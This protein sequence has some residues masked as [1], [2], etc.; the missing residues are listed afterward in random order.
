MASLK[1]QDKDFMDI[2]LDD[3]LEDVQNLDKVVIPDPDRH[4]R[5]GAGVL[6]YDNVKYAVGLRWLVAEDDADIELAKSRAGALEADFYALR[7]NVARQQGFGYLAMGHRVGMPALAA[8]IGDV[9]VGEWHGVF[10]ADNGW[11]Y[12]AVHADNIAPD[13]DAFFTSEEQAYTHFIAR[14]EAH[15]WPRSYAPESWNIQGSSGEIDLSK[16]LD[17]IVGG[18]PSLKP[19]TLDAV[20]S[21]KANKN[22][23]LGAGVVIVAVLVAVMLG[24]QIFPTLLPTQAQL[25]VPAV[26]VS[27][28][29]QLPPE[30]FNMQERAQASDLLAFTL[31]RPSNF[32]RDCLAGVSGISM[33]LPGWR[34]A[35]VECRPGLATANW[36][37]G[38]GSFDITGTYL[39]R[40]PKG[41]SIDTATPGSV[42]AT[43]SLAPTP[44]ETTP[45]VLLEQVDAR[46]ILSRRFERLG[47]F[48]SA[49]VTPAPA[50]ELLRNYNRAQEATFSAM[51]NGG[52][53][54]NP[55]TYNDLPY[56]GMSLETQTPPNLIAHYFDIPGAI[57]QGVSW[58]SQG[59]RWKYDVKVIL[60]PERRLVEANIKAK[61]A[62]PH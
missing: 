5:L 21:G 7:Q 8:S 13:G 43:A 37:R 51:G 2:D 62:Q 33:P 55:I 23:A 32:V 25:P 31:A 18:T 14:S 48:S 1:D 10:V 12:M 50:D 38:T 9:L 27:D 36:A 61:A 58:Q 34:L 6:V 40:F 3:A 57:L 17:E 19:V 52:V 26:E 20:F 29:L 11:W 16:V 47:M 28:D 41:V 53:V 59:G 30:S 46:R 54:L 24:T 22:L 35:Q 42:V 44:A 45:P 39:S 60:K 4:A 49:F 56:V 15:P